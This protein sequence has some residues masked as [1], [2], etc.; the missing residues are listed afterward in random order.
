MGLGTSRG[1]AGISRGSD[2]GHPGVSQ[3]QGFRGAA[4]SQIFQPRII[5]IVDVGR[6]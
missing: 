3:G 1:V 2:R 5:Q 4:T 6:R